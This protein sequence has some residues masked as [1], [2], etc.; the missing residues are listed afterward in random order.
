MIAPSQAP[1]PAFTSPVAPRYAPRLAE[2]LTLDQAAAYLGLHA[3]TVRRYI[4]EGKLAAFR[5]RESIHDL[6]RGVGAFCTEACCR[7]TEFEG[8][9]FSPA[10]TRLTFRRTKTPRVRWQ[11]SSWRLEIEGTTRLT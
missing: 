4:R 7:G 9:T 6:D 10:P 1:T 8:L 5:S 11:L 2:L 3:N